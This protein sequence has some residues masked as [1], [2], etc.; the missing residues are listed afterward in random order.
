M[1]TAL[2]LAAGISFSSPIHDEVV[3]AGNFGEPRPNHFHG[4]IDVKTGGVEKKAVCAVADGYVSRVTTGLYGFGNAIYITHPNGVTTAYCHL[5]SFSAGIE[6]LVRRWRY[7]HRCSF[8][9]DARFGPTDYPVSEG[10]FIALSGNTGS[11]T[12]PHLHLEFHDTKT[13]AMLDPLRFLSEYVKDTTPPV[14]HGI[15][16]YPQKGEG[17]FC[18]SEG[19]Q[20]YAVSANG[21]GRVFTAGGKVGF[22]LW[23]NDYTETAY[24]HLGVYKTQLLCD[25]RE[26]FCSIVDSVSVNDNRQINIWGDHAHYLRSHV[27]Y[28][29]SYIEPGCRLG[30]LRADGNGG[31]VDFD[32][33]RTYKLEYILTDRKGNT[34]HYEFTVEGR[35]YS[36][37]PT[38]GGKASA[39]LLISGGRTSHY[40]I[41]GTLQLTVPRGALGH[42]TRLSPLTV[43]QPDGLSAKYSFSTAACPL[44]VYAELSIRVQETVDDTSKL[45][46]SSNRTKYIGGEYKAGWL[47]GRIRE[48]GDAYEIKYDD[49]EPVITAAGTPDSWTAS[50]CIRLGLTDNESGMRSYEASVDGRFVYFSPMEKSNIIQCRL[51]DTPVAK[52]GKHHTLRVTATDNCGNE[53]AY[54]A[55][56]IW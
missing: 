41:P 55:R 35:P 44:A 8:I 3:L 51:K 12:A 28:L 34:S 2:L 14:A 11:S 49:T 47:T 45:Y 16:V 30:F 6:R 25:G 7:N 20:I 4:G 54:T 21:T 10:Q 48:L 37:R 36:P 24:N 42:D 31:I 39:R 50:G 9:T 56:F 19:N 33:Q 43:P 52:T 17:M 22:G 23:A 53:S 27:W 40:S 38:G 29:K 5:R 18:G 26:V 32:S 46:L 1:L 13:W 15:M